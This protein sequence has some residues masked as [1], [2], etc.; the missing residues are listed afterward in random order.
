LAAE[1]FRL[2]LKAN[3]E[4]HN[5]AERLRRLTPRS[6]KAYGPV[7]DGVYR[8]T[9]K[10]NDRSLEA[11]TNSPPGP[12][13]RLAKHT[14]EPCQE[15]RLEGQGDGFYQVTALQDGK[16]LDVNALS[17]LS[18]ASV[19]LWKTNGGANQS[20]QLVPNPDGTYRLM[21]E[22]SGLALQFAK[23]VEANGT[24][25]QQ[26]EWRGLDRQK[27]RLKKIADASER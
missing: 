11:V 22:H 1:N 3:P 16:A 25:L 5:A 4:N 24:A 26:M 20:W 19:I 18:G 13:L 2:A 14:P 10:A 12:S 8:L 21:N 17:L 15:W 27:W 23:P 7:S 9:N 6:E